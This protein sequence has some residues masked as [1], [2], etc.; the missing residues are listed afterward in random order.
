MVGETKD[1]K[2]NYYFEGFDRK[3]QVTYPDK[4]FNNQKYFERV[5][6]GVFIMKE[7]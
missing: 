1:G 7:D 5:S 2:V 4:Y 3:Y 6:S